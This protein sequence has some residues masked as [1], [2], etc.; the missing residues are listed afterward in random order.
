MTN[1]PLEQF[2]DQPVA[3]EGVLRA[4]LAEMLIPFAAG[5]P[6]DGK[7]LL[8]SPWLQLDTRQQVLVVMLAKMA[9]ASKNAELQDSASPKEVET[10]T[11]LPG[12]TVRAKLYQLAKEHVLTKGDRGNY[13][14]KVSPVAIQNARS[15]LGEDIERLTEGK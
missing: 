14:M 7:I 10:I 12:G 13:S 9:L 3:L 4:T 11:G 15:I 5:D 1:D 8:K 2:F 6:R